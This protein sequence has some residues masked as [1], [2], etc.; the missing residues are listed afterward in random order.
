MAQ[1][2]YPAH[3]DPNNARNQ[4]IAKVFL[5][6]LS[7]EM[8]QK[9]ELLKFLRSDIGASVASTLAPSLSR[10]YEKQTQEDQNEIALL[11][12]IGMG[13]AAAIRFALE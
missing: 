1:P 5:E 2:R 3:T 7:R 10:E 4:E 11:A 12:G 6:G 9:G 13:V 8:H